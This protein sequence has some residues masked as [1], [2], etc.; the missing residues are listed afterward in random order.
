MDIG[1]KGYLN[2]DDLR[3]AYKHGFTADQ[4]EEVVREYGEEKK[5]KLG[6]L[7]KML[8]PQGWEIEGVNIE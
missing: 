6:G 2:F 3:K 7:C 4:L 8:L 5:I 1:D